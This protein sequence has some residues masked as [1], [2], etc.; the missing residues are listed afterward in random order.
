VETGTF[1]LLSP[2]VITS[3]AAEAFGLGL[4]GTLTAYPSY[5]NRVYEVRTLDGE[6]FIAKFYRPGRWT[7]EAILEEHAFVADCAA[8]DVPVVAPLATSDGHT[9][10]GVIA[11]D[12]GAGTEQEYLFALYPRRGGRSF[13]AESDED[14]I[15]LG[16]LSGRVHAAAV[17]GTAEHRLV[18]TPAGSTAA[19]LAELR[20]DGVVHPEYAEEF[21]GT[22]ERALSWVAPLFDGVE[23]GRIHGD[24]H[25]GNI[26]DRPGEGLLLVDFDDM[27]VGPAVQDL[28]LLLPGR[29][30]ESRREIN[31]ILEGYEQFAELDRE[32]LRLIEP[33]RL[34]RMLYYLA[35]SS[36]QRHDRRFIESFPEWGGKAFWGKELEDLHTQIGVIRDEL[37]GE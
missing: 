36:R 12:D 33:L 35:W 19:F 15:R 18:C 34:M 11:A 21:F 26:L 29:L 10:C 22:A 14:W 28:W 6:S 31:L 32:S 2:H 9:L 1:D 13:D 17:R 24:F 23:L 25:R 37:E 30:H 27:M 4:D 20:R 3:A 5:V 7:D 16:A 8:L